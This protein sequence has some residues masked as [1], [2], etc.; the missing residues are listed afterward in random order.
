MF[1]VIIIIAVIVVLAYLGTALSQYPGYIE[2]GLS[3]GSFQM[4]IW[5]FLL[6]LLAVIIVAMIGFKILWVFFRLPSISKRFGKRHREVKAS[7]LL[8]KGMLAMGKGQWKKAEKILSKGARVSYKSNKQD[9]G[10]FLSAAAQAAQKQGAAARRDQYLL[11]ARQLA[12]EG[13]D[14]FSAALA[15]A[16]L[17]LDANEAEQALT[18]LKPHRAQHYGNVKLQTLETQAYEQLGQYDDAWHALANQRKAFAN[19]ADYQA[20]KAEVAQKLFHSLD[21]KLDS[22]EKV[23]SELPKEAKADDTLILSYVSA[24]LNAGA[25]EK[26]EMVLSK[27]VVHTYSDPLIHAYTQLE[28]GSARERLNKMQRWV[29]AKPENAY[30]NYGAAKLALQ[31]EEYGKA[32]DFA[33]AS[34]KAQPLPEALALLGRVYQALGQKDNALQAYRTAV[35]MTYGEEQTTV[36]GEVLT[37][38]ET[39]PVLAGDVVDDNSTSDK[40]AANPAIA[41]DS[42]E[43]PATQTVNAKPQ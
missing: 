32:K 42:G 6:A 27:A 43:K 7:Q 15:E 40:A 3:S 34:I 2:I 13:Q 9:T 23:W 41:D 22:I 38:P 4:P 33:E 31:L 28:A 19:K 24:L 35:G 20:R 11:E 18:V 37:A 36:S 14:T 26:A 16:Q 12:A 1:A 8:Q 5:Y 29:S 39:V 10:L 21:A 30:L 17:H 25:K